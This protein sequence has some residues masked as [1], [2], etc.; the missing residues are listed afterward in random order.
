MNTHR[1]HKMVRSESSI[2]TL[3]VELVKKHYFRYI[4]FEKGWF[5][6]DNIKISTLPVTEC[7][8][9]G[10]QLSINQVEIT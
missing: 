6:A 9:C 4:L 7:H 5:F 1:C 3:I 10:E 8:Y 2:N